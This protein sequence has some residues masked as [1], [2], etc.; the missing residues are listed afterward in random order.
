MST[1]RNKFLAKPPKYTKKNLTSLDFCRHFWTNFRQMPNPSNEGLVLCDTLSQI[2][3]TCKDDETKE[4]L[5]NLMNNFHQKKVAIDEDLRT[6][7]GLSSNE[8]KVLGFMYIP[9][10]NSG[11]GYL[12]NEKISHGTGMCK[13]SIKN[14]IRKFKKLGLIEAYYKRE[15]TKTLRNFIFTEK[16]YNDSEIF[17]CN[18]IKKPMVKTGVNE[19][20]NLH[21][22]ATSPVKSQGQNLATKN[23]STNIDN[24]ISNNIL[25]SNKVNTEYSEL[26]QRV[27]KKRR[28]KSTSRNKLETHK[29]PWP[30][31]D[32][33]IDNFVDT[34]YKDGQ[35]ILKVLW[36]IRLTRIYGSRKNRK[37]TLKLKNNELIS[38]LNHVYD[39]SKGNACASMAIL[40]VSN[41]QYYDK[42][43]EPNLKTS[44]A[45]RDK[46]YSYLIKY[47]DRI[48]SGLNENDPR[49]EKNLELKHKALDK[50]STWHRVK[51]GLPSNFNNEYTSTM[52]YVEIP[53]LTKKSRF[54]VETFYTETNNLL[55][56][57]TRVNKE[58]EQWTLGMA[59]Q[60]KKIGDRANC[61]GAGVPLYNLNGSQKINFVSHCLEPSNLEPR[62]GVESY[63][64]P[65]AKYDSNPTYNLESYDDDGPTYSYG[66][67][68]DLESYEKF[69]IFDSFNNEEDEGL[70]A[71]DTCA[72]NPESTKEL[73][74]IEEQE[75][76]EKTKFEVETKETPPPIFAS[77]PSPLGRE[78]VIR[79]K[80]SDLRGVNE[81]K[82]KS[83]PPGTKQ[84]LNCV[85]TALNEKVEKYEE[86]DPEFV[87]K[88]LEIAKANLMRKDE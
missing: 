20:Q 34:N 35:E 55:R 8:S 74:Y 65:K 25:L 42:E 4:K 31:Y 49:Y 45:F 57:F 9:T 5:L 86:P 73:R 88:C 67:T 48:N 71:Y 28:T 38:R 75:T 58:K 12:T 80:L 76:E 66:P 17:K 85:K 83:I 79:P 27:D 29:F 54:D 72:Y 39:I 1:L 37:E 13:S 26:K 23:N 53:K 15:G 63:G 60:N 82:C 61:Q 78:Y 52:S 56:E 84:G 44:I 32:E 19:C 30:S 68:Y 40:A 69:D 47:S 62:K 2:I 10:S 43:Y 11:I 22:M 70:C 7:W 50:L 41:K 3:K 21:E 81:E 6:Y 51:H 36:R 87:K 18:S 77:P 24:N 16:F 14:Y 46:L 33:I 64:S 59:E